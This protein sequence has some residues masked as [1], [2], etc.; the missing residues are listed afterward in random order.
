MRLRVTHTTR[1]TYPLLAFKSS[2]EAR[3]MPMTNTDQTCEEFLLTLQPTAEVFEEST[4][5]G[6]VHR[7]EIPETHS[8]LLIKAVSC[9]TTHSRDPFTRMDTCGNDLTAFTQASS[10]Q[11]HIDY[12]AP[13]RRVPHLTEAHHIALEVRK[14]ANES[15][16]TFLFALN[17]YIYQSFAYSPGAT[18]VETPLRQFVE[19]GR[20]VCQD[21]A[22]LMLAVCRSEG[23][24]ARYVSGY[25]YTGEV[26]PEEAQIYDAREREW[27]A[28]DWGE[29]P[30]HG[31]TPHLNSG[32]ATHAWVECLLPNGEWCGF[33]PTNNILTDTHYIKVHIGRDYDD[34]APV[35]GVYWGGASDPPE[36][37]VQIVAL[38]EGVQVAHEED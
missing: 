24:P 27:Y 10:T 16:A 37:S 30:H 8:S 34:V 6:V 31:R 19:Q 9:V 32:A 3:L 23:I 4:P 11:S 21:F 15:T 18:T 12:L 1:Y 13:S 33:D 14:F 36:V 38:L 29:I 25:L 35:R 22:H 20:G 28:A 26:A 5:N 2:N 7:F 17:R